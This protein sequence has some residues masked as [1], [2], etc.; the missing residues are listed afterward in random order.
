[1][2]TLQ[3]GVQYL[4]IE[5]DNFHEEAD[6]M[7]ALADMTDQRTVPNVFVGGVHVVRLGRITPAPSSIPSSGSG[8]MSFHVLASDA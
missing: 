1:M 5:L 4:A 7:D 3:R 2:W 6:I 8:Q